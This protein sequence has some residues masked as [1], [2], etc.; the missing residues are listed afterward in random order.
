M[1][2]G[3]E[4]TIHWLAATMEIF[5]RF[6]GDPIR[7]QGVSARIRRIRGLLKGTAKRNILMQTMALPQSLRIVVIYRVDAR[8][9]IVQAVDLFLNIRA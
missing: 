4:S 9:Q 7:I 8:H 1:V 6:I 2:Q 5:R 3:E